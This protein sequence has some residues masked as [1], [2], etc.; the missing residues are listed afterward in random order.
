V[1]VAE[2][3]CCVGVEAYMYLNICVNVYTQTSYLQCVEWPR[4]TRTY[5][6]AYMCKHACLCIHNKYNQHTVYAHAYI[7]TCMHINKH[8]YTHTPINANMCLCMHTYRYSK[9]CTCTHICTQTHT[10]ANCTIVVQGGETLM[11]LL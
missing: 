5:E 2:N 8:T 10:N 4:G 7:H 11:H 1:G 6:C 3:Q 9:I